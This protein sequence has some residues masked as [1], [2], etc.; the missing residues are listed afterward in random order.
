MPSIFAALDEGGRLLLARVYGGVPPPQFPTV[1][2]LSSLVSYG[3]NIGV[4]LREIVSDD[5]RIVFRT[6]ASDTRED[7]SGITRLTQPLHSLTSVFSLA[8]VE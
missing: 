2:L 6:C 4:G 7:P 1:A 8:G 5:V 3:E